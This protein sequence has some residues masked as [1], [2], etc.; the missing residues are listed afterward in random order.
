MALV[1]PPMARSARSAF[2]TESGVMM[3]L[4]ESLDAASAIA[5]RPLASAARMRSAWTAG[6]AAVPGRLKPNVSVRQAMVLTVPM[7]AQVPAVT[8]RVPST[9]SISSAVSSPPR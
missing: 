3:R 6:I 4:G 2:S 9:V 1:E 8:A 5:W 7:T